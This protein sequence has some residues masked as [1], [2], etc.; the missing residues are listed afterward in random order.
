MEIR[1]NENTQ[2]LFELNLVLVFLTNYGGFFLT[3]KK[4][5]LSKSIKP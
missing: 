5:T 4:G 1:K 2:R 3:A